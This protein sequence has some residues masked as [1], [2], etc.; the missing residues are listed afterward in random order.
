[1]LLN[2]LLPKITYLICMQTKKSNIHKI[3]ENFGTKCT[4]NMASSASLKYF[5]KTYGSIGDKLKFCRNFFKGWMEDQLFSW[6]GGCYS[7]WWFESS[8][9]AFQGH[10]VALAPKSFLLLCYSFHFLWLSKDVLDDTQVL[11]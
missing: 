6:R 1:M 4:M 10:Q 7:P 2:Q 11:L 8:S 9:I 5:R 3:L